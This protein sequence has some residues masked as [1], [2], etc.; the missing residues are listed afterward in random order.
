MCREPSCDDGIKDGFETGIDCGAYGC[1][2]C[3]GN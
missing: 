3:P 2:A 1:A